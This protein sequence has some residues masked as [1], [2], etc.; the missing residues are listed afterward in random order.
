MATKNGTDQFDDGSESRDRRAKT[1][2]QRSK[3]PKARRG[4]SPTKPPSVPGIQQRRNKH[5]AW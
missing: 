5:W 3:S 4:R 1:T 2:V